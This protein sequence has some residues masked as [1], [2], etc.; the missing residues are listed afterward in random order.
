MKAIYCL[1]RQHLSRYRFPS[2]PFRF[3]GVEDVFAIFAV[4]GRIGAVTRMSARERTL[5][6]DAQS[7]AG[8]AGSGRR[9]LS[10]A[11][12]RSRSEDG[13]LGQRPIHRR[14]RIGQN[15]KVNIS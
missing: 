12:T 2:T 5:A 1:S 9:L 11:K 14:T 3:E 7:A 13:R 10:T 15:R 4:A 6:M 8:A